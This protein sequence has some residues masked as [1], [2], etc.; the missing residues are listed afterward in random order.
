MTMTKPARASKPTRTGRALTPDDL[1]AITAI[2]DPQLSPDGQQVAYVQVTVDRDTYE[3]RRSIWLVPTDGAGKPRRFTSGQNDTAPRW[4]PD[5]R[6]LAFLRAPSGEVKPSTIEERNRGKGRPQLWVMPTDGGEARRLTYLRYGVGAPV[7]SPDGQTL[8]VAA[9]IGE[10]D[11]HEV[12]DA[13]LG[14][15]GKHF[16]RVRTIDRLWYKLDSVGYIYEQRSHIFSVALADGQTR[17]LTDGDYDDGDPA[18]SPD[19]Q[20]IAFTSD[21]SAERWRWPAAAVW[22][23]DL[24]SGALTRLTD[25][26]LACSSPAWSPDGAAIAFLA[27]PRRRGVGHTDLYVTAATGTPGS[28]RLLTQDFTATCD[29]SGIDDMRSSHG[30]AHLSWSPDGREV[31]FAGSMRG[32]THIYAKRPNSNLLPRRV[33][34][35]DRRHFGFSLDASGKTLALAISSPTMPN[36]VYVQSVSAPDSA[37][38]TT[39]ARRLTAV[40]AA[41]FEQVALAE[42]EEFAFKGA[43]GWDLQGWVMRPP[44]A[45]VGEEV[46]AVLEVHGGPAAMYGYSFFFEFQLLA[47]RG[48][49]VVYSNPR[50]STGYGRVFSGAV[51][52]DWGGKDYED[53]LA[54]LDAAIAR[55]GIDQGRLGV[56]GGS[57]GGFMTNWAVGH[58]DRFKAAVTMRSVVNMATMFGVS[59]VGWSL[60]LDELS[61]TPWGDLDRLMRFSPISYVENINTP[62]LILHSD[63]DLRC[64]VEEAEQLFSALKFLERE[65]K[66]VRFEG[67]SHELSR[68]GHP[69]SRVIRLRE[70][71]GWFEKYMTVE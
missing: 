51:I 42:P 31:F 70:I 24:A 56:A 33:T 60:T 46:P 9:Q 36:D 35:G 40:N 58:S 39:E 71:V 62:L 13:E 12:D 55:G 66:L 53:V 38:P 27:S 68:A 11:D 54:G 2:Q 28:E 8:L 21:R 17:Q 30:G 47:A 41:L 52:N 15:D 67:Q 65:T 50:G 1:L 45:A 29:D 4:S 63:Q 57:Y 22:T 18:W 37:E 26:A 14:P 61:A 10:P 23:L 5:G 43:D 64:P 16:P 19:G 6:T 59:D 44:Q 32:A 20:R 25:E 7:W 48:F 3:Y 69:R 34:E 49:A